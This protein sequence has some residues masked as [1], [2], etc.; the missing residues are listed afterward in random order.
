MVARIWGFT[1]FLRCREWFGKKHPGNGGYGA[2]WAPQSDNSHV[3]VTLVTR[4]QGIFSSELYRALTVTNPFVS[5][6]GLQT[7]SIP[8]PI[9][10]QAGDPGCAFHSEHH[11]QLI[12]SIYMSNI[13]DIDVLSQ[14]ICIKH[15]GIKMHGFSLQCGQVLVASE[16][17]CQ[18]TIWGR[19]WTRDIKINIKG[20]INISFAFDPTKTWAQYSAKRFQR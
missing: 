16:K 19:E 9:I 1:R 6:H 20:E 18:G 13:I 15:P 17:G 14:L 4:D 8:S 5:N 12:S 2:G 10:L 3:N 7:C 11:E